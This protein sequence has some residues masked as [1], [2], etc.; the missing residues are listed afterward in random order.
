[1]GEWVHGGS[2]AWGRVMH[3]GCG[4]TGEGMEVGGVGEGGEIQ[5]Y[6]I[7]SF[8]KINRS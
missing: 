8:E 4:C 1:M 2:G 7:I 6:C 3:G 5:D